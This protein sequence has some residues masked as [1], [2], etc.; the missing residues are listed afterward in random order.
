MPECVSV[1]IPC[2]NQAHFVAEAIESALAQTHGDVDVVVVDDCSP[3][4]PEAVVARYQ[5]VRYL[6][7]PENRGPSAARNTGLRASRGRFVVF[8][9]ADDR[10]LPH[11]VATALEIFRRRPDLALVCGDYQWFGAEGTWHRH[12]CS[13][14]PDYYAAL[15]RF[16]FITPPATVMVKRTA[17]LAV[18][19]FREDLR[20]NEDRDLWLRVT[21]LYPIHC[22]HQVVAEYRRHPNQLTQ[23]WGVMLST[24]IRVMR[25]QWPFVKDNRVY[26]EAYRQGVRQYQDACGPP[27]VWQM[28]ADARAGRIRN[29]LA[30]LHTVVR[31]YPQGLAMLL[32]HKFERVWSPSKAL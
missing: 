31:Y 26:S 22:H 9:D 11:H 13:D 32:R 19:G 17:L 10:L 3:D 25:D 16:G 14:Q 18:G 2:Y 28:V 6:R 23:R 12:S 1:V 7:H 29:A 24:G 20:F 8:L 15:L 21:R 27:L 5:G 4:H 30:A